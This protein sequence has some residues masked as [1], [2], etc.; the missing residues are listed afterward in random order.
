M[1]ASGFGPLPPLFTQVLE[2][3]LLWEG[4][5]VEG[6]LKNLFQ[7]ALTFSICSDSIV[8]GRRKEKKLVHRVVLVPA[9]FPPS[10]HSFPFTADGKEAIFLT[11]DFR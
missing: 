3:V 9:E 1:Q 4:G 5:F 11:F 8:V 6:E 10:F 7:K 2:E